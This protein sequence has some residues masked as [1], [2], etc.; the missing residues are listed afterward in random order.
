MLKCFGVVFTS[1]E[2]RNKEIDTR[3][4]KENAVLRELYH[5]AVTKR[6]FQTPQSYFKSIFVPIFEL[7]YMVMSLA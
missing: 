2:R 7:T 4:G 1:V 5:F 3:I 6:E